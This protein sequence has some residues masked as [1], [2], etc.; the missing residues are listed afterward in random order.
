MNDNGE[1]IWVTFSD[2]VF[3][4]LTFLW[5]TSI[6]IVLPTSKRAGESKWTLC[7][8]EGEHICCGL[9]VTVTEIC[10]F[11]DFKEFSFLKY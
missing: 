11:L 1:H 3:S 9:A 8:R 5:L 2:H 6:D 7:S 4:Q 10:I